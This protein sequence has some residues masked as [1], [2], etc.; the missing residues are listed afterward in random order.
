MY[1]KVNKSLSV[2]L[3]ELSQSEHT[4]MITTLFKI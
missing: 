2:W 4:Q 3:T 1:I